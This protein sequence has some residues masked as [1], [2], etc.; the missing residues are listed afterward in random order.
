MSVRGATY[1]NAAPPV[2]AGMLMLSGTRGTRSPNAPNSDRARVSATIG[3]DQGFGTAS[4][5][6]A[7]DQVRLAMIRSPAAR[8]LR[9][10]EHCDTK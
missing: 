5:A 2:C 1:E 3:S 7:T 4:G 8:M 9:L 6:A 10:A